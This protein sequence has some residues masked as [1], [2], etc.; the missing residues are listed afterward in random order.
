MVGDAKRDAE[1]LR[2]N[3]PVLQAARIRAPVLLVHGELDERVPIVHARDMRKA[4]QD[5]GQEP[6]WLT[7]SEEGHGWRKVENQQAFAQRMVS[8]L[9]RHLGPAPPDATAARP[10]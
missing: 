4:L 10:P 6:E 2:Q 8:F 9:A 7:F 3:S 1:M 5:A